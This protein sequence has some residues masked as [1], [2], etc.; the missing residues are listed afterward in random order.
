[1]VCVLVCGLFVVDLVGNVCMFV[2][3]IKWDWWEYL[4][5][6]LWYVGMLELVNYWS[7]M[8]VEN[9]EF[10]VFVVVVEFGMFYCVVEKLNLI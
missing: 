10:E 7:V 5:G 6:L 9:L 3:I 4:W 2:M 8:K 1:M